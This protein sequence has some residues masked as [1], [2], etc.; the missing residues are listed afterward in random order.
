MLIYGVEASVLRGLVSFTL[1]LQDDTMFLLSREQGDKVS[2]REQI[3]D[4]AS[5]VLSRTVRSK[6]IICNLLSP[7]HF[8][9]ESSMN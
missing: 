8:V 5:S 9:I 1:L 4:F 7:G 6:S 2:Q 3:E